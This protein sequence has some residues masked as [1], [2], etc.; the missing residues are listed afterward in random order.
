METKHLN[1]KHT[2]VLKLLWDAEQEILD[3]IDCFCHKYEL[4]YS[5]AYGTLLGAVRHGGFIPWD[6]DVDIMMPREDY[7]RFKKLWAEDTPRGFILQDEDIG[8]TYVN[9]FMK[10]R[11]DHTTFLQFES[12]RNVPYQNGVFVDIFPLDRQ[13]QGRI[14]QRIQQYEL[15]LNLLFNRGYVSGRGGLSGF[16]EKALLIIVPRRNYRKASLWFGKR[17]RRWNDQKGS[18]LFVP[19]TMRSCRSM[20]PADMFDRMQR[21]E[22]RGKKYDAVSD[23][24]RVLTIAY[25][26]YMELPP[27]SEQVWRHHPIILDLHRNFDELSEEE[28]QG[29]FVSA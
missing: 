29:S 1:D 5:I 4:K 17:S 12:E 27:E 2:E 19:C 24:D 13:A 26:D 23:A 21:I 25:G 7:E 10:V 22:F 18:S 16:C 9:T 14:A 15:M 3:A 20:Y 28:Q 8:N 6:D 11:K